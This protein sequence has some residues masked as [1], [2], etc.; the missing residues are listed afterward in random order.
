MNKKLYNKNTKLFNTGDSVEVN[1]ENG[2][3]EWVNLRNEYCINTNSGKDIYVYRD[4]KFILLKDIVS[5]KRYLKVPITPKQDKYKKYKNIHKESSK[6]NNKKAISKYYIGKI[7]GHNKQLTNKK[8][9]EAKVEAY[10]T[11]QK[12]PEDLFALL[13]RLPGSYGSRQ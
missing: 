5:N 1:G 13:N 4:G 10:F 11:Q 8:M 9:L 2:V 12:Q 7:Y 6:K 3:V